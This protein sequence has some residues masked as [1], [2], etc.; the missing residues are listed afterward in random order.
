MKRSSLH[1]AAVFLRP[2]R[3]HLS[4][5]VLL[6][7]GLSVLAMLPP[8]LI[9][10]VINRVIMGGQRHLLLP[11]GAFMVLLPIIHASCSFL[12]VLSISF[13]GQ[14]FVMA[15]RCAVYRHFMALSMRF[16]GKQSV[17]TLVNR[18]M[19]D[20]GVLQQMLSMA[21]V[22]IISDLVCS[23]FAIGVTFALN[24]RLAIPL[25]LIVT[26]FLINYRM[27][28]VRIRQVTRSYRGAEDRLAG[29]VQ[30]RLV[31]DLT[32]KT[33]GAETREHET[34][35]DQSVSNLSLVR[36]T[37]YATNT[38][39]MNTMLLR[40]IGRIGIY[41][42]GCALVLRERASYGDV[43][44][45]SAYA[46]Q[47]LLPA[48]RFSN[49]ARQLQQVKVSLDRLFEILDEKPD[50]RSRPNAKPLGRVAGTIDF[51]HVGFEYESFRPV[52]RDV[53]F[54]V[55][56]GETVA[57]VGPTGCGKTTILSLLLRFF[58]V[59]SGAILVDGA[60][61]RDVELASL[62]SQ[63]GIVLQESLLFD[64]SIADNIRYSRQNASLEQVRHAAQVAEIHD[65]ILSLPGGYEAV[66]GDRNVQLSVGEKQR[67]S[68][69]RAV[70]ADPPI[71]IMDE[72]TSALDSE[73]ERAI[74]HAMDK[75]LVGRT[76][77]IVA[78]RLSTIRNAGRIILL[79]RGRIREMGSHRDLMAVPDG[80]Y[81]DLYE[82]HS[83]KG[84]IADDG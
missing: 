42:L 17:G 11:L 43:V 71:L 6:T 2:F 54:H 51:N 73:S 82:K 65:V 34:F 37:E 84:I 14:K 25:V 1:N 26:L 28:I 47:L 79:D 53:D 76:S 7:A 78:H 81:R 21:S 45:F 33:Y 50:I 8:L 63:F 15:V 48:V 75:F 5:L 35:R 16:Y 83:G 30:S 52:L 31:A 55:R 46:M 58:D 64:I 69:A 60:D 23:V 36:E 4:G 39:S 9:R 10:A 32:V 77:F 19:G 29:G 27:N 70:L 62:R 38:F 56:A 13:V 57:L 44:A 59:K 40:D 67:M 24:W 74:Q 49:I 66:V 61:L 80:K 72:A 20:S 22:Q 41:F 12:Q 3:W 68:I 18:L